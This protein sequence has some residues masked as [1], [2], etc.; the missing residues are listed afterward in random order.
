MKNSK[1]FGILENW[2]ENGGEVFYTDL[3]RMR[4]R[5]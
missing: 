2:S 3:V 1:N 5:V 4:R